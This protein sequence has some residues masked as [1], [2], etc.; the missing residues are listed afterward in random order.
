MI[1][2]A[3][4]A[5]LAASG[6]LKAQDTAAIYTSPAYSYTP[7]YYTPSVS[8]VPSY[9]Y[10]TPTASYAM[11]TIS[12][13][14]RNYSNAAVNRPFNP[15]VVLTERPTIQ[16]EGLPF[17]YYTRSDSYPFYNPVLGT[18]YYQPDYNPGVTNGFYPNRYPSAYAPYRT[19][20]Q[21]TPYFRAWAPMSR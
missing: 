9:V 12:Y 4:L 10:T 20:W 17:G 14:Y 21:G 15:P 19:Y 8:Y 6:T 1:T 13:T 18:Y 5:F 7:S 16:T 11:P 3:S 2:A